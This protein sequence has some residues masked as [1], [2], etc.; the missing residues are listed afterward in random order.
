MVLN[1]VLGIPIFL[2][3]MYLMFMFTINVGSAFID[4]FDILF[5]TVLV[6]GIARSF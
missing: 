4:F 3:V 2:A 6:D 5:G 1:R